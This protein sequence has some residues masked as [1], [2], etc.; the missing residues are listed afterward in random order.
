LKMTDPKGSVQ[1][2]QALRL[3]VIKPYKRFTNSC[4]LPAGRRVR[5]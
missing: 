2:F 4:N 1:F 3:P 5:A